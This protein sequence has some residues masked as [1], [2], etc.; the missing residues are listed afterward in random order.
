MRPLTLNHHRQHLNYGAK[1]TPAISDL[2]TYPVFRFKSE[3]F[4]T[5]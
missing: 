3:T 1:K 2:E 5:L 4:K